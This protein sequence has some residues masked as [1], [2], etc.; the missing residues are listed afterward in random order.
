MSGNY[1]NEKTDDKQ[2]IWSGLKI[3]LSAMAFN[4]N[5]V[6]FLYQPHILK[7]L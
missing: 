4:K 5:A 2:K 7:Y 6:P 1:C 3:K